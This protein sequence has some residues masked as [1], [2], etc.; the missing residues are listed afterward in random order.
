MPKV[1]VY[2]MEGNKVGEMELNDE[3]FAAPVNT[4]LMHQA[5]VAYLAN[6]RQG[7]A[8]T[9]TRGEVRG[10]GRKPWRQKGTGRARHGSIR[11]PI[12]VGGGV[13]FGPKPRDYRLALPKKARRQA[14]KSA[15]STKVSAGNLIIVDKLQFDE[16]KTRK[17]VEVLKNL[18][19]N[20]KA[21]VVTASDGRNVV[22]SARNIP[23]VS[24]IRAQDLNVYAVLNSE[25]LVMTK[26]AVEVVEEVLA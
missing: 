6:Q 2:N 10:G 11:S 22:L 16:P 25:Q 20:G 13:V 12:W 15:L 4:A 17:M 18:Q 14:L 8:S 26:E 23:G 7:T 1:A 21:L 9:K 19:V 5:V 3:I 24:T